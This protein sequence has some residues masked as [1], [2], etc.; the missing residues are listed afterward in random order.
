MLGDL[1]SCYAMKLKAAG[2]RV[3]QS[4]FLGAPHTVAGLDGSWKVGT[5]IM[6]GKVI[7]AMKPELLG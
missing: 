6:N 5:S 7:A 2:N 3:E 1:F 4:R